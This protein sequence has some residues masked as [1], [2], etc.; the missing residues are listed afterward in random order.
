MVVAL[1]WCGVVPAPWKHVPAAHVHLE[2]SVTH[3]HKRMCWRKTVLKIKVRGE[4]EKSRPVW[5][6]VCVVTN[7]PYDS[8]SSH[9]SHHMSQSENLMVC[10]MMFR[11]RKHPDREPTIQHLHV[12]VLG[13]QAGCAWVCL[14]ARAPQSG[15]ESKDIERQVKGECTC[16]RLSVWMCPAHTY[17]ADSPVT[18]V[19]PLE[20]PCGAQTHT[21]TRQTGRSRERDLDTASTPSRACPSLHRRRPSSFHDLWFWR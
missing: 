17:R 14:G 3:V 8:I 5:H 10:D 15:R 9:C 21:E 11:R 18:S 13:G 2:Q 16:E 7:R 12:H 4:I 6:T 19:T 1:W 20:E